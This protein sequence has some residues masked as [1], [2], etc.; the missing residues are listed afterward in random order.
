MNPGFLSY[1]LLTLSLI[2]IGFGWRTHAI[3]GASARAASLFGLGWIAAAAVDWKAG[4]WAGTAAYAPLLA[5]AAIG[6]V[7]PYSRKDA[8]SALSFGCLLG[9][10]YS[11]VQ[12]VERIDPLAIV[13][14]PSVDP[15]ALIVVLIVCYTR[16]ASTQFAMLSIALVVN[17]AYTALLY[18][19]W[20][21]PFFGGREFQDAW[22]MAAASARALSV[23]AAAVVDRA[24]R[25]G[26]RIRAWLRVRR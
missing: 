25:E 5:L 7:S 1:I 3:G 9:A 15:V 19:R 12:L 14:H 13:L 22:W 20:Q 18:A 16:R 24:K 8:A 21:T 26:G 2:L 17:D 6:L 23:A 10:I 4:A 11:L